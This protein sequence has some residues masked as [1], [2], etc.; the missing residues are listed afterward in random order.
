MIEALRILEQVGDSTPFGRLLGLVV[1]EVQVRGRPSGAGVPESY[2]ERSLVPDREGLSP[3][4]PVVFAGIESTERPVVE[5]GVSEEREVIIYE[6]SRTVRPHFWFNPESGREEE[7]IAVAHLNIG[8][9]AAGDGRSYRH[10]LTHDKRVIREVIRRD[11]PQLPV[12]Q[13]RVLND[14]AIDGL[15][16]RLAS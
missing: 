10:T 7:A 9:I 12:E 4:F 16:K 11:G 15:V 1:E 13:P 14:E 5:A 2:V 3:Y 8:T 6:A